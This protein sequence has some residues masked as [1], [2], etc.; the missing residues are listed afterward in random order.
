MPNSTSHL[1]TR[2]TTCS[3]PVLLTSSMPDWAPYSTWT[4]LTIA[5]ILAVGRADWNPIHGMNWKLL[6]NPA[7][8]N[9]MVC[10]EMIQEYSD[11][12]GAR[13]GSFCL[14]PKL[15]EVVRSRVGEEDRITSFT[16][17]TSENSSAMGEHMAFPITSPCKTSAMSIASLDRTHLCKLSQEM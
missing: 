5:V 13:G 12:V 2:F 14:V 3:I 10:Y 15:I 6:Q 7:L 4:T 1:T 16:G 11:A 8:S 17:S 9:A